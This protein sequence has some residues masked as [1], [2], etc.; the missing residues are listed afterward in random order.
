MFIG[1]M[2]LFGLLN[3]LLY[4]DVEVLDLFIFAL[5]LDELLNELLKLKF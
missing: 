5:G 1:F 3:V 2:F 4:N